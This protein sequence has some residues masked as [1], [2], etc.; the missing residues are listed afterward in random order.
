MATTRILLIS[1][2]TL[3]GSGYLDHAESVIR[4]FLG[5]NARIAFVPF[6]L[7]DWDEYEAK[8]KERFAS[9]GYALESIHHYEGRVQKLLDA[10]DA[11]FVGGGNTFRLLN[12]LYE[13][14]LLGK[15]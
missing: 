14:D 11:I 9:M 1:N 12:R 10:S 4:D 6:A 2:S 15:M 7:F 5:K 13:R 3:Y 8:A